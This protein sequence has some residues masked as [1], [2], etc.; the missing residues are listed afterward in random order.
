[1]FE[2]RS[3]RLVAK[4]L[5]FGKNAA[6][7]TGLVNTEIAAFVALV[8]EQI[9]SEA[10]AVLDTRFV[11]DGVVEA[12]GSGTVVSVAFVG[13]GNAFFRSTAGAPI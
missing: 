10:S 13:R 4:T 5:L 2:R 12:V 9:P 1:M 6:P 8:A 3:E 11:V 7:K